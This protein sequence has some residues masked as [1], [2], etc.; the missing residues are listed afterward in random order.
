MERSGMKERKGI[1]A[2]MDHRCSCVLGV[3]I[4]R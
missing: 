2:P 4:L 1:A 3:E